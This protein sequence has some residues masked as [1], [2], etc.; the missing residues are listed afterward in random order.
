MQ[1]TLIPQRRDA[2]LTLSIA[3]DVLSVDGE[4]FDFSALAEG[5]EMPA[6]AIASDHFAGPVTRRNGELHLS[7]ILPNG[8]RPPQEA[9]FPAVLNIIAD[10]PVTLPA[11]EIEEP[12]E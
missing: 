6:S 10:G 9:M 1:I 5:A 2:P 3:G 7:L 8:P 11:F 4:L 12:A